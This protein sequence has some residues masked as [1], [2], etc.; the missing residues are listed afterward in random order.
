MRVILKGI[1]RTI[2]SFEAKRKFKNLL[3]D[4][5]PDLVYILC[6]QSKMS[7]SIVDAARE[8]NIPIIHRISDYS[9]FCAT[10]HYYRTK[11]NTI[12]ELCSKNHY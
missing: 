11:D 4:I 5:R 2:Y 12:C 8:L 3:I 7:Y 10:A 6:V 9:L 1:S